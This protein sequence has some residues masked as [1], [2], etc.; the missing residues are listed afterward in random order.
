MDAWKKW[1]PPLEKTVAAVVV[2]STTGNGDPPENCARFYRFLKRRTQPKDLL[3][4]VHYTVLGLGDTNYDKFCF[5]GKA[6]HSRFA[7]LGASCFMDPAWADEGT[8]LE[9]GVEPFLA[10][11]PGALLALFAQLRG[12]AAGAAAAGAG[13]APPPAKARVEAGTGAPVAAGGGAAAPAAAAAAAVEEV[14]LPAPSARPAGGGPAGVGPARRPAPGRGGPGRG[15]DGP[16]AGPRPAAGPHRQPGWRRRRRRVD[17]RPPVPRP[18]TKRI[19]HKRSLLPFKCVQVVH[20]ELGLEPPPAGS[21]GGGGAALAYQPGDAVGVRC[22]NDARDVAFVLGRL[23]RCHGRD[24]AGESVRPAPGGRFSGPAHW[25]PCTVRY[26][27]THYLDLTSPPRPG[28]LR[29]LADCCSVP[30]PR[31]P[32]PLLPPG[33]G[34]ACILPT[35]PCGLALS[36]VLEA[37]PSC[38]PSVDDLVAL[39]PP[40]APRYYSIACSQLARPTHLSFAFTVPLAHAL[41]TLPHHPSPCLSLSTS[42]RRVRDCARLPGSR[43]ETEEEEEEGSNSVLRKGLCTNW[44]EDILMPFLEVRGRETFGPLDIRVPIFVRPTKEFF[45]PGSNKWPIILIGPGT[46]VAPFIG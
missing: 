21:G 24:V 44:L 12:D 17:A 28:A 13:A 29:G 25:L 37:A 40:L 41:L 20:L 38:R 4:N 32:P 9:G 33:P 8:D 36:C 45:L 7:E 26:L 39:L 5:M 2:T 11:L 31:G 43:T 15:A 23:A 3:K 46:G 30:P 42:V 6:L 16:G 34:Q 14:P 35:A 19:Q 1:D 10:A 22:P 18:Q 27:L